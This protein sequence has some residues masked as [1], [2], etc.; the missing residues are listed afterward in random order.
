M[1]YANSIK[2]VIRHPRLSFDRSFSERGT[3]QLLWLTA[4]VVAVFVVLFCVSLFFPFEDIQESQIIGHF[5]RMVMLFID[6][7]SVDGLEGSTYV[8]GI[9]VAICGLLLMTGMLI[10]VLTN[11][12]DVRIDK[13]RNGETC[14]NLSSHVVIIGMDNLVPSLVEQICR[15]DKFRRM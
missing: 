1:K 11:M 7:G 10:S 13:V 5:L 9:V 4:A 3:R 6:P 15:S 2:E 14:Y 12:L 8:F